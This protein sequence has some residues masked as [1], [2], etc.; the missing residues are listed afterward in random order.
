[1]PRNRDS[2]T[3]P[4]ATDTADSG[5]ADT[6]TAAVITAWTNK[7]GSFTVKTAPLSLRTVEAENM[8]PDISLN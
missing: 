5:G 3:G 7:D 2:S 1:M 4:P 6:A 8:P